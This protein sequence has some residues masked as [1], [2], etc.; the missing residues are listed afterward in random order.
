MTVHYY[1]RQFYLSVTL[2]NSPHVTPMPTS[3]LTTPY[4]SGPYE[5]LSIY[6]LRYYSLSM[7]LGNSPH[8][9]SMPTFFLPRHIPLAQ[10]I[11]PNKILKL[12]DSGA[13]LEAV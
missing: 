8:V 12:A 9:T 13:Q 4:A 11:E 5:G 1:L 6:Y 3:F 10:V 2:E 7:T